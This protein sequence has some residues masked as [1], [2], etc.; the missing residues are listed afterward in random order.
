M[1]EIRAKVLDEVRQALAGINDHEERGFVDAIVA[2]REIFITGRGRSG[3]VG[4]AFANRLAHLGKRAHVVGEATTPAISAGDLL[5]VCS[6][7]GRTPGP[8][9]NAQQ[10]IEAGAQVWAV[11]QDPSSPLAAAAGHM[12]RIP[13]V[14][15]SQPG[16]S[17]FEQALLL[18]LDAVIVRL[19]ARLGE[20]EQTMLARHSRLE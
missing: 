10:A 9:L 13:A 11:T 7:S 1:D 12:V 14:P 19:M 16:A 6:G 20:T 8:L 2:A 17:A 3:L 18:F 5:V 15:S 4:G